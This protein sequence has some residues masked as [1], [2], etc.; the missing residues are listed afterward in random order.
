VNQI[1]TRDD[2]LIGRQF[3]ED[4]V[5]TVKEG[6]ATI[7]IAPIIEENGGFTGS[8][9]FTIYRAYSNAVDQYCVDKM[10]NELEWATKLTDAAAFMETHC[11][12]VYEYIGINY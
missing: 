6:Y 9:T 12:L 7:D 1:G 2:V 8:N 5:E 4:L 3:W 10:L 11:F